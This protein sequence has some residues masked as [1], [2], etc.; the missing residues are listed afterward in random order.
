MDDRDSTLAADFGAATT[1]ERFM[2]MMNERIG[3][4]EEA[5]LGIRDSLADLASFI[6]T[7]VVV[8]HMTVLKSA[9]VDQTSFVRAVIAAVQKTPRVAVATAWAIV[10][11]RGGDGNSVA[12][13]L[14][15]KSRV[16]PL[17]VSDGM[18][19]SILLAFDRAVCNLCPWLAVSPANLL[20][21]C[22]G[23]NVLRVDASEYV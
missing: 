3:G 16:V 9:H 21:A 17:Q 19:E 4:I 18:N 14:Q 23:P 22:A 1:L 12:L 8:S 13:Y 20:R 5:V 6:T 7:D 2:M 10:T 11:D 15:L